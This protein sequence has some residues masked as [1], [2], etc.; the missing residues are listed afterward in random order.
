MTGRPR[1]LRDAV[2]RALLGTLGALIAGAT[3]SAG[4]CRAFR[5]APP[6]WEAD[7]LGSA[8]ERLWPTTRDAAE[9]L[10]RRG[11]HAQ[12]DSVLGA[13]RAR[14]A[15]TGPA[16]DALFLRGLL[17][18]DPGNAAAPTRDALDDL[19]AYAAGGP[20]LPH[21]AQ[22]EVVRRLV[23]QR[24]SLRRAAA[25]ERSALAALV[26]RDSLA[27][28]DAELERLRQ[29]LERTRTELERVRRRLARPGRGR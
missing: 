25:Y 29:E 7:S 18:A 14:F 15:G 13:F 21:H 28:R 2:R 4:A 22:A 11:A 8:A 6:A 10:A 26:P 9:Q 23:V 5:P 3:L 12:A 1:H 24:D 20:S 27:A 17:R 19:A 16:A